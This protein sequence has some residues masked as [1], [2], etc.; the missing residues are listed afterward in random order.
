MSQAQAAASQSLT[1]AL[2]VA[3]SRLASFGEE[4]SPRPDGTEKMVSPVDDFVE[5]ARV[6]PIFAP[7][8]RWKRQ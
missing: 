1:A 2:K 7:A 5:Q 8:L 4:A 3:S 6:H